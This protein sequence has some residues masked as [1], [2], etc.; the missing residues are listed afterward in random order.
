M[1]RQKNKMNQ[2]KMLLLL[3]TIFKMKKKKSFQHEARDF[4]VALFYL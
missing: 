3:Q 1:E 2:D 4:P